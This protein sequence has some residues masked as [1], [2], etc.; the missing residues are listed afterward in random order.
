VTLYLAGHETTSHA[1]T[2]TWALL[3]QNPEVRA[4]LHD[5]LDRVL[6]GRPP[7][8]DDL[9]RLPYTE[10][11][12]LEAMRLYPPAFVIARRAE[13][14]TEIGGYPIPAGSEIVVWI[15]HTHRDPRWYPEP[16]AFR[17]ER[18]AEAVAAARPKLA[19]LP[20]GA[21]PRACIGAQFSLL[22]ARLVLA[23]IAQRFTL[24]IA[25]GHRPAMRPGVTLVPKGGMPMTIVSRSPTPSRPA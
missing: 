7:G 16:L 20:F 25:A 2:W 15:F 23:T 6:E 14:D 18:H 13:V 5:E 1:L 17:P 21:G 19:Y 8:W 22:E 11:V 4:R 24:D 12:V 3:S 9:P 10:Q